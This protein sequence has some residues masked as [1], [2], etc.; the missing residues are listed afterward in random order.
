MP[1]E[2]AT[3]LGAMLNVGSFSGVVVMGLSI[4]HLGVRK[5][6]VVFMSLAFLVMVAFGNLSLN[7]VAM[8]VL[9]YFHWVSGTGWI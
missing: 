2:M 1:F 8:F 6:I 9:T 5:V 4:R 3:Y 7:Y